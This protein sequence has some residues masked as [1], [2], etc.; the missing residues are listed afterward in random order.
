MS[1]ADWK[2]AN[3]TYLERQWKISTEN[4]LY[5]NILNDDGRT[6]VQQP[7]G[8]V[9]ALRYSKRPGLFCLGQETGACFLVVVV[10]GA[11]TKRK[12]YILQ[13]DL[14]YGGTTN[15]DFKSLGDKYWAAH[16][17]GKNASSGKW[18]KAH[19]RNCQPGPSDV[20]PTPPGRP[21]EFSSRASSP[22]VP[23][24]SVSSSSTS[25]QVPPPA[26]QSPNPPLPS[27]LGF[28]QNVPP[29]S[30]GLVGAVASAISPVTKGK[31]VVFLLSKLQFVNLCGSLCVC[32]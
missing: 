7:L 13:E 8:R 14:F 28:P 6:R 21:S 12:E 4:V 3:P 16:R 31:V 20:L 10:D 30:P 5:V 29:S 26:A 22:A 1:A 15:S 32:L 23:N 27:L 2:D 9:D 24:T 18:L 11:Q 19:L 25:S 17:Q